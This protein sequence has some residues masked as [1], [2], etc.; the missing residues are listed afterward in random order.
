MGKH[1]KY[2]KVTPEES[3]E[4]QLLAFEQGYKWGVGNEKEPRALEYPYLF[5]DSYRKCFY[6]S[7]YDDSSYQRD[8]DRLTLDEI[9]V[10]LGV[11]KSFLDL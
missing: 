6:C 5:L 10:F 4:V 11:T 1:I 8:C 2:V 7:E 3:K 9:Y